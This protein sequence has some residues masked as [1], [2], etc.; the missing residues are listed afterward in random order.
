M[1]RRKFQLYIWDC[2]LRDW[3]CGIAVALARDVDEARR[4]IIEEY[5]GCMDGWVS[6]TLLSDLYEPPS[7]ILDGP[8][9]VYT[10]GVS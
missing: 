2:V 10:S 1:P 9:G 7:R 5:K 6:P 8:A 3:S 4:V